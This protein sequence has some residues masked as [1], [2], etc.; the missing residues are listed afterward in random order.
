MERTG[1]AETATSLTKAPDNGMP[2]RVDNVQDSTSAITMLSTPCSSANQSTS[3]KLVF[4]GSIRRPC[5]GKKEIQLRGVSSRLVR[6]SESWLRITRSRNWW[7]W[8]QIFLGNPPLHRVFVPGRKRERNY[9]P[10]FFFLRS[11]RLCP[12]SG[13]RLQN[14]SGQVPAGIMLSGS[15]IPASRSKKRER[16]IA[17]P[18]SLRAQRGRAP[19]PSHMC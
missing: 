12:F 5:D 11:Q 7:S 16:N 9:V 13:L 19:R 17:P 18:F 6:Q 2:I 4:Q 14:G 15:G 8:L 10:S 1:W 3:T